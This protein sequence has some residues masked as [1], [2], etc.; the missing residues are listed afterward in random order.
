MNLEILFK[1]VHLDIITV[2]F[3]DQGHRSKF[4][5]AGGEMLLR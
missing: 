4:T 1:L 3:E 5:D 2:N